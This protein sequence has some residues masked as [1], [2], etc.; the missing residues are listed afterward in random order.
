MLVQLDMVLHPSWEPVLEQL[1]PEYGGKVRFYKVDCD[2]DPA[3]AQRFGVTSI[4]NL[5]MRGL[6]ETL[7]KKNIGENRVFLAQGADELA[8]SILAADEA[9]RNGFTPRIALKYNDASSPN[10]V[11]PYMGATLEKTALE[12]IRFTGGVSVAS[13]DDADMILYVSA[14]DKTMQKERKRA[15]DEDYV[16]YHGKNGRRDRRGKIHRRDEQRHRRLLRV[17][18]RFFLFFAFVLQFDRKM[19]YEFQRQAEHID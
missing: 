14:H 1:A 9:A 6:S 19:V 3:L 16:V 12:K 7:V 15:G 18:Y 2:N 13:P 4:P 5:V 17:S 11:L 10:R 8:L